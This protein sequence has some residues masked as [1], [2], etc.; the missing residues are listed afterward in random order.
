MIDIEQCEYKYTHI[1]LQ[2]VGRHKPTYMCRIENAAADTSSNGSK[3]NQK[4][5]ALGQDINRYII[6]MMPST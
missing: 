2:A 4:T 6:L 1:L 3:A 5:G